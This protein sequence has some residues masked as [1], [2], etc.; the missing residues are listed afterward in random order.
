MKRVLWALAFWGGTQEPT[1]A[2][3]FLRRVRPTQVFIISMES[4]E[5][6]SLPSTHNMFEH[7]RIQI[8]KSF[9]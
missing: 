4:V 3:S 1:L 7:K 5:S 6:R 9:L 8:A 2:L